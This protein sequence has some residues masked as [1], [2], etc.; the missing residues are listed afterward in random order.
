MGILYLLAALVAG[1]LWADTSGAPGTPVY[2]EASIANAAANVPDFFAANTFLTIYGQNLSY[3]IKAISPDDIHAGTLPATLQGT[4][5]TVLINQVPAD[6]YYVS[7]FQVNVL[8]PSSLR[9]GPVTIQLENYGAAGP[10]IS[11]PLGN[12]APALFQMDATTVI[13]THGNGPLVTQA[14]PAKPGE[15]VVLYATGLGVTSPPAIPNQIP[16]AIAPLADMGNFQVLL[17][18]TPVSAKAIQYAGVT[19]GFAGLFQINL[20]LPANSPANPEVRVSSSGVLSPP[21]RIL[22]LAQVQ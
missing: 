12:A 7:P 2:T 5:V 14:S 16:T 4:G 11:V 21:G 19:P 10:P 15:V 8:I 20:L 9:P 22:P 6:M 1:P 3:V 17:N 13:A 18:G